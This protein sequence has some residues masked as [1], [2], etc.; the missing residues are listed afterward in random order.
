MWGL[1]DFVIMKTLII[2][3]IV[4]CAVLVVSA[5]VRGLGAFYED[6]E[7]LKAGDTQ[8][9]TLQ[10]HKQNRMMGQRVL[11]QGIAIILIVILGS[12]ASQ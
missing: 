10:S 7:R 9:A 6:A 12:L 4:M 5:L 3:L 8:A 2:V 11:F 1:S